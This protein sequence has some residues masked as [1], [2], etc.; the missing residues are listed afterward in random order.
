MFRSLLFSFSEPSGPVRLVVHHVLVSVA[1]PK[2]WDPSVV[3]VPEVCAS[4]TAQVSNVVG[5]FLGLEI[6]VKL[7]S[8]KWTLCSLIPVVESLLGEVVM[9]PVTEN[10]PGA[11]IQVIIGVFVRVVVVILVGEAIWRVRSHRSSGFLCA[12]VSC[13][14][15]GLTDK[16]PNI[17]FVG[18]SAL[19][20]HYLVV[21]VSV[22]TISPRSH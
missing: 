1:G 7:S 3:V 16:V 14:T 17:I 11:L 2:V 18:E 5:S 10:I 13:L 19:V 9:F 4:T 12:S 20:V 8:M 6:P 22:V 21:E 15:P